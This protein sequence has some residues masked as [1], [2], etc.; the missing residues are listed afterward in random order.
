MTEPAWRTDTTSKPQR[1]VP[2]AAANGRAQR[3]DER[4]GATDG[5]AERVGRDRRPST[6]TPPAEP[7]V[8]G[9]S[10][11][12]TARNIAIARTYGLSNHRVAS[13]ATDSRVSSISGSARRP[14]TSRAKPLATAGGGTQP[15]EARPNACSTGW[16]R[17]P[18]S[19]HA[20]ASAGETC[21]IDA[22]VASAVSSMTIRVPSPNM[23][24]P[25]VVRHQ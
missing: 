24:V 10:P 23:C 19:T 20:A 18:S 12:N 5:A 14:A 22:A 21:S 2:P 4:L 1:T 17:S 8:H 13:S 9:A 7:G 6:G 25:F 3:V 11:E 16:L 15:S